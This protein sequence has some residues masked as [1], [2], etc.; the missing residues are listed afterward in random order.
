MQKLIL[1][2]FVFLGLSFISV[3][4]AVAPAKGPLSKKERQNAIKFLKD[5][6]SD[7]LNKIQGLSEAQLTFKPAPD[8]W[9]VEECLKHIAV[10][11][12]ALWQMASGTLKQPANP[13]K[14]SEIKMTDDQVIAMIENRTQKKQTMDQFKPEN[15]PYKTME[16]ALASFKS[17]RG[18]LIMYVRSTQ[19]D[20]RDHVATMPFGMLDCYQLILFIGAHSNRHAQQMAEVMA[21]PGFPKN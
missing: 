10:T 8:R 17:D 6:E 14:R 12:Q 1:F 4:D 3:K 13:D 5:T 21:D 19:E 9:S 18:K 11:E 15:T 7:V 20:L 16:E 2:S